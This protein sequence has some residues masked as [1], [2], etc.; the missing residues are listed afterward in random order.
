MSAL[1]EHF[2]HHRSHLL[3]CA[4][5]ALLVVVAIVFSIPILA[6]IG[7]ALCASMMV[8]MVWMMFSMASKGHH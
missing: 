6:V 7:G 3:G 2:I 4:L 1:K 5:A 8:M